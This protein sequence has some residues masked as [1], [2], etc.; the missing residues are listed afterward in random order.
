MV[1]TLVLSLSLIFGFELAAPASLLFNTN[2][3]WKYF[4]GRAEA[5]TPDNTAWRQPGF[6]DST[7]TDASAP[8]RY[9]D[10]LPGGTQLT[11]MMN[12]YTTIYMRRS[13][14]IDDL[15]EVSGLRLGFRCDDG[16]IAWINGVEVYR[17]NVPGGQRA[18]NS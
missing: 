10:V 17:Y 18:F 6:D 3:V 12:Q 11:D 4:K 7:F 2:A 13:F 15:A 5:S 14:T 1:K 9:G 8:F 16:F